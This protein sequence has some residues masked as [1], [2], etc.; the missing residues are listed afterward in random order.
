[1]TELAITPIATVHSPYKQKF[2][3][4]R[5]PRLIDSA[6][7]EIHLEGEFSHPD[8]VRGLDEFTHIWL[9][10]SFHQTREKGY[11]ALVRPPRLGGNAKK[12]VFATRAT[13]RPNGLGMSA[14]KLERIDIING[15]AVLSLNPGKRVKFITLRLS[16][17]MV[18]MLS[19]RI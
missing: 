19:I 16:S 17:D 11:S 2:A 18:P 4:P 3:I 15:K 5:Q 10:F 7:G 9:I 13:F 6:I 1:M 8:F 12:G 14:V